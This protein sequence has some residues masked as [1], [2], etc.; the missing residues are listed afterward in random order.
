MP[1]KVDALRVPRAHDKRIKLTDLQRDEIAA[2][3]RESIHALAREY[4]VSRRLI[5]FIQYPERLEANLI[6]RQERSGSALYYD[7]EKHREAMRS[8]R[9]HKKAIY[10]D[11]TKG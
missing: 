7:K 1:S 10:F 8:H 11:D 5:Q 3:R 6:K 4:G 2:R 9:K